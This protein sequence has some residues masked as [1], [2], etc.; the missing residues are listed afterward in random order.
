MGWF[1]K[2]EVG[3][4]VDEINKTIKLKIWSNQRTFMLK[5]I[6]DK[7]DKYGY[8]KLDYSKLLIEHFKS[9]GY[10]YVKYSE[11]DD[12][13]ELCI[14]DFYLSESKTIN[15][16]LKLNEFIDCD[17]F[18]KEINESDSNELKKII[19]KQNVHINFLNNKL[20]KLT[21]LVDDLKNVVE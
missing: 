3:I 16:N 21:E 5:K 12:F 14:D 11:S 10:F 2:D 17:N 6:P 18:T 4:D 8:K 9:N 7:I 1:S 20:S 13:V 19:T 15:V